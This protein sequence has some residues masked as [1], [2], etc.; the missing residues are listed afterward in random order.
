MTALQDLRASYVFNYSY[1][2]YY[3]Q[4]RSA[5]SYL[6]LSGGTDVAAAEQLLL[7]AFHLRLGDRPVANTN[8]PLPA[9]WTARLLHADLL[10]LAER[11]FQPEGV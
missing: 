4:Y 8:A 2:N 6:P 1:Q 10:A 5:V 9:I 11:L 3:Q 7:S